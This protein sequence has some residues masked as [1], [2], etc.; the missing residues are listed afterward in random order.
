[1][2]LCQL[3]RESRAQYTLR[4]YIAL[5][6]SGFHSSVTS[7]QQPASTATHWSTLPH[8]SVFVGHQ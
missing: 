4:I 2:G 3:F 1:M 8:L 7:I 6:K 5:N